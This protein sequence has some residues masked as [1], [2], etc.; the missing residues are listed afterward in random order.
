MNAANGFY[1]IMSC[2]LEISALR[3]AISN[4]VKVPNPNTVKILLV[5]SF[6]EV[7]S[8]LIGVLKMKVILHH[9]L[10]NLITVS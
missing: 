8:Y 3:R 2:S 10:L 7:L 5:V 9:L 4:Y 6:S 1:F